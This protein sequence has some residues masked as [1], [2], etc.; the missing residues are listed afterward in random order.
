MINQTIVNQSCATKGSISLNVTGNN[1]PYTYQWNPASIGNTPNALNLNAGAYAV[2]VTDSKNCPSV[3]KSFT[4]TSDI[5]SLNVT[6]QFK[7]V[8]CKDANDGEITLT[9]SGGCTPYTITWSDGLSANQL[10][11]IEPFWSCI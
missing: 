8:T 3:S 2:T 7:D 11:R 1:P 5:T 6:S 10:K 9:V 4:I